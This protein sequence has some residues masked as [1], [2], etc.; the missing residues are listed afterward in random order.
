LERLP[1]AVLRIGEIA[2]RKFNSVNAAERSTGVGAADNAV[3][4]NRKIS[5]REAAAYL[6]ISKSFL[7]KKR[8]H[9]TGPVYLKIGRRVAYDLGD[10][11]IWVAGQKRRHTSEVARL[12]GA[13]QP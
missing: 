2:M 8:L 10:L 12:P 6:G 7:D 13:V 3:F 4:A 1:A 5:V 9:G 11:E